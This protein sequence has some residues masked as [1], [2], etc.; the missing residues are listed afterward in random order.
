MDYAMVQ[1]EPV[2]SS[3]AD[4]LRTEFGWG[5][6]STGLGRI[7]LGYGILIGGTLLG[8]A[9]VV[10]AV[11]SLM[12]TANA[13]PKNLTFVWIFY[14]GGSL[15]S[16]IGLIGYGVILAGKWRCLMGAPE[17]HGAKWLM[18]GC[19]TC[20]VM[21]PALNVV[22]AVTGV[23]KAPDFKRGAA[24]FKQMQFSKL[25]GVMQLAGAG[26]S[27]GSLA[28]FLLF[29]RAVARCFDNTPAVAHVTLFMLVMG[30]LIG[31]T[32][33]VL[34]GHPKLL[35]QPRIL[36][37][38]AGGWVVGFFWYL[39]LMGKMRGCINAGLNEIRS[40]LDLR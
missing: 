8:V 31:G 23:A 34:Y 14:I 24:G 40:P 21:G 38:L 13:G 19:M 5:E 37:G 12:T 30:L 32:A 26:I 15:I 22:T 25:G 28:F 2:S 33:F 18:F 10:F 20:I 16:T 9:L 3:N 27:L 36:L 35:V 4:H 17:R 1:E 7:C 11:Y 39:V 6:V 29:L